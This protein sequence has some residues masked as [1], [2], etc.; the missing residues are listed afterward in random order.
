MIALN[1]FMGISGNEWNNVPGVAP[2]KAWDQVTAFDNNLA[3][4]AGDNLVDIL[5]AIDDLALGGTDTHFAANNLTSTGNRLHTFTGHSLTIQGASSIDFNTDGIL[6]IEGTCAQ[7]KSDVAAEGGCLR[8]FESSSN[9][10]NYIGLHGPDNGGAA[11]TASYAITLPR[12]TASA[13]GRVLKVLSGGGTND[14]ELE[15]GTDTDTHFANTNLTST[16]NRTHTFTGHTFRLTGATSIDLETSGVA[17]VKSTA[18]KIISDLTAAGGTIQFFGGSSFNSNYVSLKA[19]NNTSAVMGYTLPNALPAANGYVLSSTTAGV[20][21]WIDPAANDTHFANTDLT[22]NGNRLHEFAANTLTIQGTG[23]HVYKGGTMILEGTSGFNLQ[24]DVSV[25]VK[26]V[27][28]TNKGLLKIAEQGQNG[29]NNIGITVPDAITSNYTMTLPATTPSAN[30]KI[31]KVLSGGG[32]ASPVLEWGDDSGSAT[33][34]SITSGTLVAASEARTANFDTNSLTLDNMTTMQMNASTSV[35]ATAP[36]TAVRNDTGANAGVLRV[37]EAGNSTGDEYVGITVAAD[38]GTAY[39]M[40]LPAATPTANGKI[41]KVLSGG[42][43]AS[44]VLE[45]GDD[46]GSATDT[47]ITAGTLLVASGNRSADF[48]GFSVDLTNAT[49]IGFSGSSTVTATG[50]SLDVRN[51]TSSLAGKIRVFEEADHAGDHFFS[52]SA[53]TGM[54][55]DY[56]YT[57]PSGYPSANDYVLTSSTTGTLE[58]KH[59]PDL[60]THERAYI[61]LDTDYTAGTQINLDGSSANQTLSSGD[62]IVMVGITSQGDLANSKKISFWVDGMKADVAG[63]GGA[64]VTATYVST[65]AISLNQNLPAGTVVEVERIS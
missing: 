48:G 2:G 50:T 28:S 42:G 35:T 23:A 62:T 31:L 38:V 57:W 25:I 53:A 7:I 52:L 12:A 39:T 1:S 40:T 10:T 19:P 30:G 55:A 21:S 34:T 16:G 47:S 44:P 17:T 24:S 59:A 6:G 9:G 36:F 14:L 49:T 56:D 32:T 3:G 4:V 33:D 65:T 29:T 41:L 60:T 20:W 22:A 5:Q 8:L 64:H 15:W 63:T 54:T 61:T 11:M 43:T 46:T 13:N 26:G 37:Y 51:A 45:W 27:A 58:W 18:T